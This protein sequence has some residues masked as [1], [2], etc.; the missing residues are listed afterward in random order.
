MQGVPKDELD[1]MPHLKQWIDR[2]AEKPAVQLAIG[3]KY[4][5]DSYGDDKKDAK[6]MV[7][8]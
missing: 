5:L 3:K 6:G 2:I 1:K 8:F 4:S 7:H